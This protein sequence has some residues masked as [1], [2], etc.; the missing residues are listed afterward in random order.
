MQKF[1]MLS[2][3]VLLLT[4]NAYCQPATP[5]SAVSPFAA[6]TVDD[7]LM[8]CRSDQGGCIDQVGSAMMEKFDYS[9]DICL[10]SI[11]YAKA[12]PGWLTAHPETHAMPTNDGI[13]L[14]VKSLY[15][16]G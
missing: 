4:T 5:A 15:K 9:G 14:A 7:Y 1:A 2:S 11:D 3:I 8:A 16:C 10:P 6:P 13:Y 12:V